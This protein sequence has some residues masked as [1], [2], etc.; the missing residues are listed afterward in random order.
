MDNTEEL[1][2]AIDYILNKNPLS[3][4]VS[5]HIHNDWDFRGQHGISIGVETKPN[6]FPTFSLDLEG[7]S[8]EECRRLQFIVVT[9][10]KKIYVNVEQLEHIHK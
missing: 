5:L 4:R 2:R 6:Y 1:E 3:V 8:E 7:H 9:E 10:I